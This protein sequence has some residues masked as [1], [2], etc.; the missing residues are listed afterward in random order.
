M[1]SITWQSLERDNMKILITGGNGFIARH[2]KEYFGEHEMVAPTHSQLDWTN[3]FDVDKFFEISGKFDVVLHT[4]ITG[5]KRTKVDTNQVLADNLTM[6]NNL[7]TNRRYYKRFINFGT[8]AEL[9]RRRNIDVSNKVVTS[10]PIDPY[11]MSKNLIARIIEDTDDF[12]NI[13]LFNVFAHDEDTARFIKTNIQRYINHD[14]LT[15]DMD[16]IMDFFYIDDLMTV[17]S[18]YMH[19]DP[20]FL[21]KEMNAVYKDKITL[22]DI[23]G[24]INQLSDYRCPIKIDRGG[25]ELSYYGEAHP[26]ILPTLPLIGLGEGLKIMYNQLR[27]K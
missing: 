8:G 21:S 25:V 5:G 10:F 16:R 14:T 23:C 2:L 3:G 13:R 6:F 18:Y 12:Y 27:D 4:A 20:F 19:S 15:V 11:G 7:Y 26:S 9:D 24:V 22:T 1:K 17:V